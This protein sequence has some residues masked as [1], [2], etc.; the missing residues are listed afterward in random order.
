MNGELIAGTVG[1][2]PAVLNKRV[3]V[4]QGAYVPPAQ[5]TVSQTATRIQREQALP[6]NQ[7]ALHPKIDLYRV[8]GK[9]NN[10]YSS[11][12]WVGPDLSGANLKCGCFGGGCEVFNAGGPNLP[13]S[14]DFWVSKET[15]SVWVFCQ[16]HGWKE[17]TLNRLYRVDNTPVTG[18]VQSDR[19]QSLNGLFPSG[20]AGLPEGFGE[21]M[22]V[23]SGLGALTTMKRMGM[24]APAPTKVEDRGSYWIITYDNGTFDN[25]PKDLTAIA[26]AAET[27]HA[28]GQTDLEAKY[29][30]WVTNMKAGN[31]PV[32]VGGFFSNAFAQHPVIATTVAVSGAAILIGGIWY[33]VKHR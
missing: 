18:W 5:Q 4:P 3:I 15:T 28:A 31:P 17:F 1:L 22:T 19:I 27:A 10:S 20:T 7:P 24:G 12:T 9:N 30:M 32:V 25:V 13:A 11:F 2:G 26:L 6:S 21:N 8:K 14:T 16:S 23:E 29:T 33:L